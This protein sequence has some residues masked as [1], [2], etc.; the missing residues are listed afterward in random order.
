MRFK[1]PVDGDVT[2]DDVVKGPISINNREIDDLIIQ[3]SDGVPTYNFAVVV[4]DWD[5][6]IT[7]VL[8]GDDHVNNTPRQINILHALGD[9]YSGTSLV[10]S[11]KL[12]AHGV[13]LRGQ[14]VRSLPD[15]ML[16]TFQ[17]ANE[18][19]RGQLFNIYERKE[20]PLGHAVTG[21]ARLKLQVRDEPL[22]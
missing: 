7:H 14:L 6:Q 4:D 5:M 3:R 11:T 15:S 9:S 13:K 21:S 19:D 10:V 17:P 18:S 2:W 16:D 12:P 8:R 20:L 22:R 1:N